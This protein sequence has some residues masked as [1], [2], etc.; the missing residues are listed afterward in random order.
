MK[1]FTAVTVGYTYNE[2][3]ESAKEKVKQ[4]YLDDP[5]RNDILYEDIMLYLYDNFKLSEL[6][7]MYSLGYCQGDGLNIYGN[8][9]LYDFLDIWQASPKEKR[10]IKFYIDRAFYQ[11]T[12]EYNNKY[13]YSCKFI[14]KKHIDDTVEEFITELQ[15]NQ[16][17]NIKKPLISQFFNDMIDYFESLDAEFEDNGYNYLYNCDD[18]EIEE[19]S[20]ANKWYF[21]ETGEFIGDIFNNTITTDICIS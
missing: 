3:S 14:D 20:E 11:Y 1:T 4:W 2:L 15:D 19:A 21:T 7:V 6:N 10:T 8:L 16:I 17:S 5:I 18:E 9:N 12:F 13:C